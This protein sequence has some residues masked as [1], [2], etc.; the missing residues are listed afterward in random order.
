M[1]NFFG[2]KAP[3]QAQTKETQLISADMTINEIISKYPISVKVFAKYGITCAGCHMGHHETLRQGIAG[4]GIPLEPIL[5]D[6]NRF[7]KESNQ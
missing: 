7:A 2:K 6:L 1:F 5:S 3:K 4:H